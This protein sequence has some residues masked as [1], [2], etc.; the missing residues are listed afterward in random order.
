MRSGTRSIPL[1]VG[2]LACDLRLTAPIGGA[3]DPFVRRVTQIDSD[4]RLTRQRCSIS[5]SP[6]RRDLT[7]SI[8]QVRSGLE[9]SN[10]NFH[11]DPKL[12]DC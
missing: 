3:I 12:Y 4:I 9:P 11:V 5:H 1:A 8:A 2:M 6:G 10:F 7:N